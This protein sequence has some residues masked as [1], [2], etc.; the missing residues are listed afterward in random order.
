MKKSKNPSR[1]ALSTRD[2]LLIEQVIRDQIATNESIHKRAGLNRHPSTITRITARLCESGW[3]VDFPLIY[4]CKYFLPGRQATAAFGLPASRSYPL[5][6]QSLPTEFAL[7]EYTSAN[8]TQV[9]RLLPSELQSQYPWY[10]PV[11]KFALHCLRKTEHKQILELIR[12]DLGGPADHIARKCRDDISAQTAVPAFREMLLRAEF[13][14]VVITGSTSKAAA[15]QSALEAHQW[16]EGI[17]FRLAVF[18]SLL[19]LLPRG[20]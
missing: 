5:G 13:C 8:S 2:R 10:R 3:L 15:I 12:V 11:W 7:L 6:P 19:P 16:P 9:Q 20:V 1:S 4:P 18:V 17:V 14:L